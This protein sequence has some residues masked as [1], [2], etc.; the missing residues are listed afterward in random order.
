MSREERLLEA[1]NQ[2]QSDK[3]AIQDL[4]LQVRE[5]EHQL[6]REWLETALNY[7]C[8][9]INWAMLHRRMTGRR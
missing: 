8:V 3:R 7:D 2:L 6:K 1:L 9:Q 5:R 4:Q